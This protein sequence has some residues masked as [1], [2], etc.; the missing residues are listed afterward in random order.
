MLVMSQLNIQNIRHMK[1]HWLFAFLTSAVFEETRPL[2]LYLNATSSFLL[3]VL[4]ISSA[5]A[6]DLSSKIEPWERVE[7]D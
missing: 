1:V 5:M 6:N 2:T 4:H 7:L 3:D